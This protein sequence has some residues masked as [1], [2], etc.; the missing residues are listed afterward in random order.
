MCW[1]LPSCVLIGRCRL[2]AAGLTNGHYPPHNCNLSGPG[3]NCRRAAVPSTNP[4]GESRA[5]PLMQLIS[6]TPGQDL[7]YVLVRAEQCSAVRCRCNRLHA[8]DRRSR[9]SEEVWTTMMVVNCIIASGFPQ[10][11]DG[12]CVEGYECSSIRWIVCSWIQTQVQ[13]ADGQLL[14]FG[15][16]TEQAYEYAVEETSKVAVTL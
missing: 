1:R 11:H 3:C 5:R 15:P 12:W 14:P 9:R 10:L 6:Q 2:Q 16:A 7:V 4:P 13:A 8:I